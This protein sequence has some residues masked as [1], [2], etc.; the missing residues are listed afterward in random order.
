MR[1]ALGTALGVVVS[2]ALSAL[3][4]GCTFLIAFDE[5]PSLD[6]SAPLDA[7]TEPAPAEDAGADEPAPVADGGDAD[8]PA[9]LTPACDATFPLDQIKGCAGFVEGGQ[10]CADH[11][12]F[13]AYPGDRT[14]DV[15]TC[16]KAGATCVRHCVACAHNPNGF[17]DQCDQCTGKPNGTYCGTDMGWQP[18]NFRLLVTCNADR[19]TTSIACSTRGCDSRGGAG[20]AACK[21]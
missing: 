19:M 4:L 7:A 17:P 5:V 11:A 14:R 15:V 6:A 13:T 20:D 8:A 21:P 3:A 9:P 16:S 1:R 12:G 18:T 10:I 2:G